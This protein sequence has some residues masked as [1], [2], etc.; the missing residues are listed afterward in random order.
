MRKRISSRGVGLPI[1]NWGFCLVALVTGWVVWVLVG[2]DTLLG[3]SVF[4]SYL[5]FLALSLYFGTRMRRVEFDASNLFV[6]RLFWWGFVKIPLS[7]IKTYEP[8]G[9]LFGHQVFISF[10]GR[11]GVGSWLLL[12]PKQPF[13]PRTTNP[14]DVTELKALIGLAQEVWARELHPASSVIGDGKSPN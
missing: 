3:V 8:Q 12:M 14:P 13:W 4:T 7:Q 1:V 2:V 6:G 10:H 11:T 5:V 9:L